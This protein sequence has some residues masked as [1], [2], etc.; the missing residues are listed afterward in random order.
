MTLQNPPPQLEAEQAES[1]RT[2]QVDPM[3]TKLKPPGTKRLKLKCV[4]LLST[5]AFKFH[6]RRYRAGT[7]SRGSCGTLW[8]SAC[9]RTPSA[10]PARRSSSSTASSRRG[11]AEHNRPISVYRLGGMPIQSCVQSV[12]APRGKAGARL[13]AHT[14]LRAKR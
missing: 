10:A 1:G 3:E 13:N 14:E 6:S 4:V 2:V 9:R 8:R 12:S 7:T 11:Q 5:S